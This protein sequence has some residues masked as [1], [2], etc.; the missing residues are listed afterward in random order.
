MTSW[1]IGS[2][3]YNCPSNPVRAKVDS[4]VT[5]ILSSS[6]MGCHSWSAGSLVGG[7]CRG[8]VCAFCSPSQQGSLSK[9]QSGVLQVMWP[10][11]TWIT[12]PSVITGY[13]PH[14]TDSPMGE[15]ILLL[16]RGVV[17]VFYSLSWQ[18]EYIDWLDVI[19]TVCQPVPRFILY[20]Y[21]CLVVS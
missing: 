14:S 20:L 7:V 9:D 8:A 17:S 6:I 19:L 15:G 16:C 21:F 4:S 11:S 18:S 13:Q 12:N 1:V 3:L 5:R 10:Q 2:G